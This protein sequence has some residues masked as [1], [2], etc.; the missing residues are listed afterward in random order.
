MKQR[1]LTIIKCAILFGALSSVAYAQ[2]KDS[3]SIAKEFIKVCN[4]YKQLPLYVNIDF[5][6][7]TNFITDEQDTLHVQAVFYIKPD[8]SYT[9]FG[10]VEQLINDSVA[11][12]ISDKLQQMV[13]SSNDQPVLERMK[14]M[15][16][17]SLQDS[18]VAEIISKYKIEKTERDGKAIIELVSRGLIYQTSLPKESIQLEFDLKTQMPVKVMTMRRNV[19]PLQESD[20]KA[21]A[22]DPSMKE[23]LV[24]IDGSSFYIIK[25]QSADFVYKTIDHSAGMK[26]PAVITDRIVKNN[27]GG[28]EPVKAYEA[29]RLITN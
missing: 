4:V 12:L 1:Y 17:L 27:E 20:Y 5:Q 21:I 6:N 15:T 13:L 2:S 7:R 11:L 9:R 22:A 18:A 28:F 16:G 19:L 24:V 10:E 14:S 26:I 29:Y 23:K 25:E 8:V 3:L